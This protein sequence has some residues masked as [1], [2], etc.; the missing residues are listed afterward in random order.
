MASCLSDHFAHVGRGQLFDLPQM[1]D[2]P[3]QRC[4]AVHALTDRGP[5]FPGDREP[6]WGQGRIDPLP[7]LVE[8]RLDLIIKRLH[9]AVVTR[10]PAAVLDLVVKNA[11]EP[12]A[13]L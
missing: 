4:Q 12:G 1:K 9:P 11:K 13:Y 10:Q 8:P 6:V 2:L 3:L 5:G 7:A